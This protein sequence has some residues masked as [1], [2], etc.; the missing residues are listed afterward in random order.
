MFTEI[1]FF[2]KLEID[3]GVRILGQPFQRFC[4]IE[5]QSSC[6]CKNIGIWL[7]LTKEF[8]TY[9]SGDIPVTLISEI[10]N[11]LADTLFQN[12]TLISLTL[13]VN[14]FSSEEERKALADAFCKNFTL[15]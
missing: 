15:T 8:I 12:I 3:K 4:Y 5:A 2:L 9:H 11:A 14:N 7:A 10:G 13:C 1:S 6:S